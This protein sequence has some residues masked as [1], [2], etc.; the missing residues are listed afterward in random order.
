MSDI[1]KMTPPWAGRPVCEN[2]AALRVMLA[3]AQARVRYLESVH[4]D[5][6]MRDQC[7]DNAANNELSQQLRQD[8]ITEW[9]MCLWPEEE[10]MPETEVFTL[11]AEQGYAAEE[12]RKC[13]HS[14]GVAFEG[15]VCVW[16]TLDE[17]AEMDAQKAAA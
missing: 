4:F 15:G 6:W 2:C 17:L 1:A 12:V 14:C 9:I 3:H 10:A 5:A 11:A 16:Y 7:N 13:A 8:E